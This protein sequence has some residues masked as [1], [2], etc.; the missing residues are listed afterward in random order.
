M[1][2]K[3]FLFFLSQFLGFAFVSREALCQTCTQITTIFYVNGVWQQ[4]IDAEKALYFQLE[5]R[6]ENRIAGT[7]VSGCVNYEV[8]YNQTDTKAADL[9][10]ALSQIYL[11]NSFLPQFWR[12]WAS[13]DPAPDEFQALAKAQA[14][15]LDLAAYVLAPELQQHVALY[16]AAIGSQH[17]NKVV[18]VAHSQGNLY[19]NEAYNILV[20]GQN[21]VP[22]SSISIVSV[23]TPASAVAG[24]GPYTTLSE[25]LIAS[26]GF[27]IVNSSVKPP[28][29][30]NP[31]PSCTPYWSCHDFVASYLWGSISGPQILNDI[32]AN[33]PIPL[34]SGATIAGRS[35]G[36]VSVSMS[37]GIDCCQSYG[38][39]WTQGAASNVSVFAYLGDP[40]GG[41]IGFQLS[42]AIGPAATASDLIGSTNLVIS[43]GQPVWRL[44]FSGLNLSAG[45][46]HLTGYGPPAANGATWYGFLNPTVVGSIGS[47]VSVSFG[48]NN[49]TAPFQRQM[50]PVASQLGFL[51]TGDPPPQS[52]S[53]TDLGV[54]PGGTNSIA[55]AIN[56]LGT[57]VGSSTEPFIWTAAGG[58]QS[59][60]A[61]PAVDIYGSGYLTMPVGGSANGINDQGLVV[62]AFG[63]GSPSGVGI[64]RPFIWTATAGF[65]ILG[66]QG[67]ATAVNNAGQVV[68]S[69][70]F[71]WTVTGGLEF[72]ESPGWISSARAIND[73]GVSAGYM[74]Y[75]YSYP[76]FWNAAGQLHYMDGLLPY[77]FSTQN[78]ANGIN[79]NGQVVGTTFGDSSSTIFPGNRSYAFFWS[80]SNGAVNLG[81]LPGTINGSPSSVA[82][83]INNS[84][85]VIGTSNNRA[86]LWTSQA[87]IQDL[88]SLLDQSGVGWTLI[89]A[90]AINDAGQI[91]GYG[92][93]NGENHAFLL[94]KESGSG[95]DNRQISATISSAGIVGTLVFTG[96]PNTREYFTWTVADGSNHLAGT[97]FT[98]FDSNGKIDFSGLNMESYVWHPTW[99][100][101]TY[102]IYA[103]A[104]LN[105]GVTDDVANCANNL[106]CVNYSY[107]VTFYRSSGVWTNSKPE[108]NLVKV[109]PLLTNGKYMSLSCS[110]LP[111]PPA[112]YDWWLWD[113]T[114]EI[115]TWDW[116]W[117]AFRAGGSGPTKPCIGNNYI[118]DLSSPGLIPGDSDVYLLVFAL[119]QSIPDLPVKDT[120]YWPGNNPVYY[121]VVHWNGTSGVIK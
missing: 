108:L 81:D 103:F 79:D 31:D 42:T 44:V 21:P 47:D 110:D 67:G 80:A 28:N 7:S 101:G 24:N 105:D 10:Q 53:V 61:P 37:G 23:A 106:V 82:N 55:Y 52:Y 99:S 34:P 75:A 72:L 84:G 70:A 8:A 107:S 6:I 20:Y 102:T 29:T 30:A 18:L 95:P 120:Q 62:G 41:N 16:S 17:E 89:S 39:S 74:M 56:N 2:R 109:T 68:G 43:P 77:T 25:D 92:I 48:P 93:H 115:P 49:P 38:V 32:L 76:V 98:S 36:T 100:D 50:F 90:N 97:G 104:S 60:G 88:N 4:K 85:K 96:T 51:V 14:A 3:L 26:V 22:P 69:P 9:I 118:F 40:G 116:N 1:K 58:M 11:D 86:F 121:G 112:G 12:W 113:L 15:S 64:Y 119:S 46:Y 13:L 54:L 91:V 71:R 114:L 94:G 63:Y 27:R 57:V 65:Q 66:I 73:G 87:G 19:A 33:I 117:K 35:P 83:G 5:H 45:T 78:Y 111:D 59:L